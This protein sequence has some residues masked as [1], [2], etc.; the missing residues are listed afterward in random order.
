MNFIAYTSSFIMLSFYCHSR[1][2]L[3]GNPCL[4]LCNKKDSGFPIKTSGMTKWDILN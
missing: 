1:D 4:Y 3:S 2:L